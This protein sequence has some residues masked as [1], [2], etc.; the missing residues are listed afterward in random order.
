MRIA[1]VDGRTA[2]VRDGMSLDV[3]RASAGTFSSDPIELLEDWAAFTAWAKGGADGEWLALETARLRAPVPAPRQV[4]ALAVNYRDHAAE[5]GATAPEHPYVFTKFPSC[6][7]GPTDDVRLPSNRADWEVELVVVI[8][9]PGER[10]QRTD[11][12]AHVAGVTIGQDISERRVQFRKP[13]P[14]LSV[15]KSYPTFGPTGPWLVTPDELA[16]PDDLAITCEINGA[17][18]QASRTSEL[19]FGVP[20]L[21]EAISAS[22]TL[23]PGDLIFTGTPAGV[24]STRD[25]RMYL[26]D[27]D[28]ITSAIEG[29]GEMNNRCV[30][31]S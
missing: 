1:N 6:I 20:E 26:T 23:L 27:G 7:V 31:A 22:V 5:A 15:S 25:P 17:E 13:F 30:Q 28:L 11:A 16:N 21:I 18:M 2:I 29:V 10:V 3:E 24:G 4:F 14:H 19:I 12:W 8:G 9:Q